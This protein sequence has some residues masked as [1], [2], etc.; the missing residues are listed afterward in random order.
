MLNLSI[1]NGIF[2]PFHIFLNKWN[3]ESHMAITENKSP[4]T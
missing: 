4:E 1:I 2:C 3:C